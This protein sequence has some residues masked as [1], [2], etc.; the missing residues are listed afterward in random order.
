MARIKML[1][2]STIISTGR[3]VF[4]PAAPILEVGRNFLF[5][6]ASKNRSQ[7]IGCRLEFSKIRGLYTSARR[8]NI[9]TQRFASA[10]HGDRRIGFEIARNLFSELANAYLNCQHI[11]PPMCT[12]WCTQF[13]ETVQYTAAISLRRIQWRP[14]ENRTNPWWRKI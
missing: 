10:C 11:F 2:S 4:A 12:H 8:R 5:T 13:G 1:A 7:A 14:P 9:D 3:S 6:H